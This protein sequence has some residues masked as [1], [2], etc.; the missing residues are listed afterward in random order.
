MTHPWLSNAALQRRAA[1]RRRQAE[2]Q[3]NDLPI[4]KSPPHN[5][6]A[7][8]K[9]AADRIAPKAGTMRARVLEAIR[10]A[11]NGLTRAEVVARV[12]IK[13][14]SVNGRCS[15]LL[16]AGLVREDGQRDGRAVLHAVDLE[17]AA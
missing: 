9:A 6:T 11:P 7:T 4:F 10:L 16:G 17:A 3:A 8:S 12:G 1:E 2:E 13:E 14:N 15:E 5:G